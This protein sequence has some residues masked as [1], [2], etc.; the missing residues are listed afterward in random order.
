MRNKDNDKEVEMHFLVINN[1]T[2]LWKEYDIYNY[3]RIQDN[4]LV[5]VYAVENMKDGKPNMAGGRDC[6]RVL[7]ES[8]PVR[9]SDLDSLSR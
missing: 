5:A 8:I 9:C 4:A 6:L 2:D 1:K 3:R 7:T